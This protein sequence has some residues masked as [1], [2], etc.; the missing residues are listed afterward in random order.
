MI[1]A[2]ARKKAQAIVGKV[3]THMALEN[4][5]VSP[6]RT[7]QEVTRLT[8]ELIYEMPSDFWEDK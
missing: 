8:N 2:Q 7:Q 3:A 4:Q 5:A 6:D 1:I